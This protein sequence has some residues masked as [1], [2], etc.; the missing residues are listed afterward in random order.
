M[1][2]RRILSTTI[3]ELHQ[4]SRDKKLYPLLFLAP[5]IQLIILGYAATFEV[6]NIATAVLDRGPDT[7]EQEVS[8]QF[9]PQ[10]VLYYYRSCC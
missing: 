2:P 8:A 10:W 7:D 1:N 4:M 3:K 9:P 6:T 5:V